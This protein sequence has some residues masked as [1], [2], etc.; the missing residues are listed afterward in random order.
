MNL[1]SKSL[2]WTFGI[3]LI[4]TL[5]APV[6]YPSARLLFFSPFI[7]VV[8]Y[9]KTLTV[10]L[11]YA[12]L[13]GLLIDLLSPS[14]R[15]GMHALDFSLATGMLYSQQRNFFA[16]SLSTLPLMTFFFS[17]LSSAISPVLLVTIGT[18]N[19]FSLD[20]V[21]TDVFFMSAIDAVYAFVLFIVP[22]MLFGKQ[23]RSGKDY[24]L[25]KEKK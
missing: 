20:W 9:Q 1:D 11:G 3:C 23:R 4:L 6:I 7:I 24:F 8:I 14:P 10:S 13:C 16:D 5:T 15:L 18:Q 2:L 17:V 25:E 19:I 22:F 21:F 12:F